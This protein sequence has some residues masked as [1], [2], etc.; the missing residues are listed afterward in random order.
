M[1]GIEVVNPMDIEKRSFEI[2]ESELKNRNLVVDEKK[3]FLVKRVIHTTA[4]FDY[5]DTL[6]FSENAIEIAEELLKNGADIVTDT[7][8]AL[9]GINKKVLAGL[10]GNA[11]CFMADESVAKEAKSRGVTRATVSM[12]RAAKINKPVIFAIG[13]APTALIS[14][15]EMMSNSDWKPDFIIGVPVGFVNVE[16]AKELFFETDIPYIINE[17]RKGGSNVAA[18]ICNALLY[19]IRKERV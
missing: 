1:R 9:S 16:A 10:G 8:M 12:E 13:N 5:A 15:F 4:D 6:R 19:D 7:N 3:S 11:T 2:I 18:A 17:G 14:I